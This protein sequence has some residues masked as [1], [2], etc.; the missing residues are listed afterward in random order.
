[1]LFL[2]FEGSSLAFMYTCARSPFSSFSA[3]ACLPRFSKT[4]SRWVFS[5]ICLAMDFSP[6]SSSSFACAIYS[7]MCLI[8][9]SSSARLRCSSRS[10]SDLS[11]TFFD[12]RLEMFEWSTAFTSS[13]S[14]KF[15]FTV[16]N[17]SF[18]AWSVYRCSFC[19]VW[20]FSSFRFSACNDFLSEWPLYSRSFSLP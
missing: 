3:S 12:S 15:F 14:L 6:S 9:G 2:I 17:F 8:S 5:W 18:N 16:S 1:M 20:A 13:I 19:W 10:N 7:I 11:A 4:S